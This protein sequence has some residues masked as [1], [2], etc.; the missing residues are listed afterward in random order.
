ME[1]EVKNTHCDMS[2]LLVVG[3]QGR[4]AQ[5]RTGYDLPIAACVLRSCVYAISMS[6]L[7]S[8]SVSR[9][10]LG[11]NLFHSRFVLLLLIVKHAAVI[12]RDSYT[13]FCRTSYYTIFN[14][15]CTRSGWS[16]LITIRSSL[17]PHPPL[18]SGLFDMVNSL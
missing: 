6:F 17:V 5:C 10:T 4:A 7:L 2:R 9:T 13:R 3:M 8:P 15:S 18:S 1:Q 11:N 14:V 16:G 12:K